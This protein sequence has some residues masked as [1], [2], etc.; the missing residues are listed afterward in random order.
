MLKKQFPRLS[1]LNST[2]LQYKDSPR[3][4]TPDCLQIIHSQQSHWVVATT[5]RRS[6]N[7]VI[8]HD[9]MF[10]ELD[11]SITSVIYNLLLER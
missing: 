2:L 5:V 8:L 1:G 6:D 11:E 3:V 4:Y 7:K 10:R 9:S